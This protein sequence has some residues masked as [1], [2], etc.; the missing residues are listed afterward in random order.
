M[1]LPK[2]ID[3]SLYVTLDEGNP[4]QAALY[5]VRE[6]GQ[7]ELLSSEVFGPFD[8]P[9]DISQWVAARLT[10]ALRAVWR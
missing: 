5:L 3:F 7:L 9:W 2:H 1:R 6:N 4:D 8:S 10:N